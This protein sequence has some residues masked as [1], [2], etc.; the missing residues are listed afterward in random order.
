MRQA[1]LSGLILLVVGVCAGVAVSSPAV[2]AAM[3]EVWVHYDYVV[4]PDGTSFAPD[5]AGIQMVVD[6]YRAHGI[7]LHVDPQH[8]AI[9]LSVPYITAFS[10]F[11][12]NFCR[13]I[14]RAHV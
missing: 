6:T 8:T 14:G 5:P 9:P 4:E 2:A 3:P 7:V 11:N 12:P 1:L 13:E 10:G